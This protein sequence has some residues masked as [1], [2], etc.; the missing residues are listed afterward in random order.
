MSGPAAA[1]RWLLRLWTNEVET[2]STEAYPGV[3]PL[4]LEL[5]PD[6]AYRAALE[7]A[8][9]MPR[10]RIVDHD[11]AG[12][13]FRAEARTRRLGFVD[14]VEVW[15]EPVSGGGSRVRARSASRVGLTDFG[16]NARRLRRYLSALACRSQE[17]PPY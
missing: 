8:R 9:G 5:A 17:P 4:E 2:G 3:E 10:W 7:T 1:R 15:I 14:D 12:R 11:A 13:R 16:T 6:P